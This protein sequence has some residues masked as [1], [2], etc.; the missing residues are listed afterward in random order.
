MRK[1][2]Y[3]ITGRILLENVEVSL[4]NLGEH[5]QKSTQKTSKFHLLDGKKVSNQLFLLQLNQQGFSQSKTFYYHSETEKKQMLTQYKNE[6]EETL[7]RF[8][9]EFYSITANMNLQ[10]N[11]V[12]DTDCCNLPMDM[13]KND[14]TTEEILE[15][16]REKAQYAPTTVPQKPK[17]IEVYFR[18]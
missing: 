4:D 11:I 3:E 17:G 13:L 14:L 8:L 6:C 12:Y 18:E 15:L 5:L 16:M 2:R 9:R 10:L 1:C 7:E